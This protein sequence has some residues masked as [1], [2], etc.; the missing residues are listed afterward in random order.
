MKITRINLILLLILTL[1]LGLRIWQLGEVP[2]GFNQDEAA[3]AFDPLCLLET[4][5]TY[6]GD[7][8]PLFFDMYGDYN[9]GLYYYLNMPFL[10]LFGDS[11]TV[12]RLPIALVGSL[13]VFLL[14]L[15]V[16]TREDSPTA[17]LAALLLAV[18][19]WAVLLSRITLREMLLPACW[20]AALYALYR[21]ITLRCSLLPAAFLFGLSFYT[22]T[23][24]RLFVPPLLL[25][26]LF[27]HHPDLKK[28]KAELPSAVLLFTLVVAPFAM[29]VAT[30]L[31]KLMARGNAI[32]VFEAGK[33]TSASLFEFL[34]NWLRHYDPM[35]LFFRGDTEPLFTVPGWGIL[36]SFLMPFVIIGLLQAIRRRSRWDWLLLGWLVCYPMADAFTQYAPHP[37]RAVAG[38]GLYEILAASGMMLCWR[39]IYQRR[40]RLAPIIACI[41]CIM[42]LLQ[43]T[44]FTRDYFGPYPAAMARE[45]HYGV[46]DAIS[47]LPP[48]KPVVITDRIHRGGMHVWRHHGP[49]W[50]RSI[51]IKA[52]RGQLPDRQTRFPAP[53]HFTFER[54]AF[55]NPF[56]LDY[57]DA[58]Y[59]LHSQERGLLPAKSIIRDLEGIV[60]WAIVDDAQ[61]HRY[62]PWM[63][64]GTPAFRLIDVEL[65][66]SRIRAGEK[67][68]VRYRIA[69][70]APCQKPMML[71]SHFFSHAS[72]WPHDIAVPHPPRAI[73]DVQPGEV[74]ELVLETAAPD[75]MQPGQYEVLCGLFEKGGGR[76]KDAN[77]RDLQYAAHFIVEAG[78]PEKAPPPR[79]ERDGQV[80]VEVVEL[81]SPK[82]PV[83]SGER[84]AVT[85]RLYF[86]TPLAEPCDL[87]IQFYNGGFFA[88][89]NNHRIPRGTVGKYERT[90][91]FV[92]PKDA[93]LGSYLG[94]I[95]LYDP[96]RYRMRL[97][98]SCERRALFA[99]LLVK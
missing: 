59:L 87:Q 4:G 50:Y 63:M 96:A 40:P 28:R 69:C 7:T 32:D 35:Y 58:A 34:H 48:D 88:L 75:N 9:E 82:E 65:S 52:K 68:A 97:I 91:S 49:G 99:D 6:T 8:W 79:W 66:R 22:Y 18:S 43:V 74:I 53:A 26:L 54:Y 90:I 38:V 25:L 5:K 11:P 93:R 2:S 78:S 3:N 77:G 92:V 13:A 95:G 45:N 15:L 42:G 62:S 20:F 70:L 71:A 84:C 23:P 24:V 67:M 86:H 29:W 16:K 85:C 83:R 57:Q 81:T 56:L 80:E 36:L 64:N 21:A 89:D 27:L 37:Q 55:G 60:L 41:V 39:F 1:G 47:Q 61:F 19:P 12:A 30:S 73:A 33:S 94:F 10:A 14:Y 98:Q 17:L 31:P 44:A 51:L 46:D 76:L 72:M